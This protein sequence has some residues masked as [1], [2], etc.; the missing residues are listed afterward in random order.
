MNGRNDMETVFEL[1]D[2]LLK[3]PQEEI[4]FALFELLRK[5]KIDFLSLNKAYVN[6]LES[7]KRDRELKLADANACTAA[8]LTNFKKENKHNHADIHWALYNLNISKQFNMA[9]LNEKFSY[10]ESQDCN[11]SFY[12]RETHGNN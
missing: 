3:C 5:G 12:W 1:L 11:Y 8:L 2:K 4:D 7:N 9:R 6:Y 10:D